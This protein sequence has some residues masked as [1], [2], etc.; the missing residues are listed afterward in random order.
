MPDAGADV[1]RLD[2]LVQP[3]TVRLHG[4]DGT[5]WGSGFLVAPGWAL[6]AAHVVRAGLGAPERLTEPFDVVL[7]EAYGQTRTV[8]A[9]LGYWPR[10]VFAYDAVPEECD[11]ALVRLLEPEPAHPCVWLSD[12]RE[13]PKGRLK[14]YGWY[15]KDGT[16]HGWDSVFAYSGKDG[17]Y[18]LRFAPD[19]EVPP[20]VSGG[21]VVDLHS[22]VVVGLVKRN[23]TFGSGDIKEGGLAVRTSL[24]GDLTAEAVCPEAVLGTD[25]YVE[26]MRL[27]DRWH[28][29]AV[30]PGVPPAG[31]YGFGAG[32]P[33]EGW[34]RTQAASPEHA[35]AAAAP[36]GA[37]TAAGH[38]SP[39]DRL[40]LLGLLS[41]LPEPGGPVRVKQLV[42]EAVYGSLGSLPPRLRTLRDGHGCLYRD[43]FSNTSLPFLRY[44]RLAALAAAHA[45]EAGDTGG[46]GYADVVRAV[47]AVEE[48]VASRVAE[49]PVDQVAQVLTLALPPQLTDAPPAHTSGTPYIPAQPSPGEREKATDPLLVCS[50]THPGDEGPTVVLE[51]EPVLWTE[52]PAFFASLR[53]Q[54]GD[55]PGGYDEH[56][57]PPGGIPYE[58]LVPSLRRPLLRLF[59][60]V[61]TERRKA[62][63]EVA[64]P[65]EHFDLGVQ[66]WMLHESAGSLDGNDPAYLPLGA[67]RQ[68][69]VRA[70][71]RKEG[72]GEDPS[73]EADVWAGRWAALG[74]VTGLETVRVPPHGL[75]LREEQLAAAA[76]GTVPALCRPAGDETGRA[77]M[78]LALRH[79]HGV[80][81]WQSSPHASGH[82]DTGCDALHERL[83][84][85]VRG[86]GSARQ[87]PEHLRVLRAR[88]HRRDYSVQ[89]AEKLSIL[90][91]D[92]SRPLPA[93]EG[94]VD[95]P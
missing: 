15:E 82:C 36:G 24:L 10:G 40:R 9:R 39:T 72:A 86:I 94:T 20:G 41:R 77:G 28:E 71:D 48:W 83:A 18:G 19:S 67:Q 85:T 58:E 2:T 68:I 1:G 75:P 76:P 80:V 64:L 21:P 5:F 11:I 47:Q 42:S 7:P 49:M 32:G 59:A 65:L 45:A 43:N 78:E 91:D 56:I 37:A 30:R 6:T 16:P 3:A 66:R 44:A 93:A 52:R 46:L 92:A 35:V 62:P 50:G 81:L 51:I 31:S 17:L 13:T 79:G 90:Y 61:D 12:R 34:H 53:V 95:S 88:F 69:V 14:A 55:E 89:W 29:A 23:S 22:N 73:P 27:H 74:D 57:E 87:L 8:R 33:G 63:L 25:P 84:K 60:T 70:L 4:A 26:L 54:V 38:W